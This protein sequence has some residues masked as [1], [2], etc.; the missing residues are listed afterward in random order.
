M[1]Y[2]DLI[3]RINYYKRLCSNDD[4]VCLCWWT[5]VIFLILFLF[6]K[7]SCMFISQNCTYLNSNIKPSTKD[8][9]LL[10]LFIC[11]AGSNEIFP[12]TYFIFHTKIYNT[13]IK[14]QERKQELVR[15]INNLYWSFTIYIYLE[16]IVSQNIKVNLKGSI[17]TVSEYNLFVL[18]LG[19]KNS[20]TFCYL[21]EL[22]FTLPII[23]I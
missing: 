5:T 18:D 22:Y 15:D 19:L 8:R 12:N 11:E 16:S 21:K 6:E 7:G 2:Y 9:K 23:I 3:L 13:S 1:K 20:N 10:C 17:F 4:L 14:Y